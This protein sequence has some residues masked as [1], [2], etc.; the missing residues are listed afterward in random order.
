MSKL[1][2]LYGIAERQHIR[3]DCFELPRTESLSLMQQ[4]QC[5]IA[6]DPFA[7]QSSADECVKLAHELGHCLTGSFY[8]RYS[9]L[10]IRQKHENRADRWAIETLIPQ[11]EL[12]KAYRQGYREIWQLAE[13]FDS[14]EDFIKKAV[15]YYA[16]TQ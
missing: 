16:K 4:G 1:I 5:Y 13:Y 12:L 2:N 11:K 6:I 10:D 7:L 8:N 15:A 9:S 3:V 14:T